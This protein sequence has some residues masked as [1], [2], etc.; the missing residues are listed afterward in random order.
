M[1]ILRN[2]G[3]R[4]WNGDEGMYTP[5]VSYEGFSPPLNLVYV[6]ADAELWVWETALRGWSFTKNFLPVTFL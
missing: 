6:F 3:D 1:L 5:Q 4:G 2:P